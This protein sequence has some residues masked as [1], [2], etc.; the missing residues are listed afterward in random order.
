MG[1]RFLETPLSVLLNLCPECEHGGTC[2]GP[3]IVPAAQGGV[4]CA[5]YKPVPDKR[6]RMKQAHVM[7]LPD[8]EPCSDCACRKGSTPS[9]TPHS[10]ADFA[11]C[12]RERQP[13]LCHADGHGRVC[14]GWLRA[15]KARAT[16]EDA[17]PS[18]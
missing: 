13:F 8:R 15:V 18:P 7:A 5:G 11:M 3:E 16:V 12:I 2:H 10:M 6:A 14:A 9:L 17:E 1:E 4:S